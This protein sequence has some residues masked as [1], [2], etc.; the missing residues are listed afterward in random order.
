MIQAEAASLRASGHRIIHLGDFNGHIGS[1][2]GQGVVGNHSSINQNGHRFLNFLQSTDSVHVNGAC[3]TPGQWDTRI[4][5]GLWT[6][7][8]GGSSSVID[9]AVVS[10]EHLNS[11]VSLVVDD[12]GRYGAG[13]SDHNWLFLEILDKF[14][15]KKRITAKS[16]GHFPAWNISD[17]QDWSGYCLNLKRRLLGSSGN[18]CDVGSLNTLICESL[19]GALTDE[20]G[21]KGPSPM[22]TP[23]RLPRNIVDELVYRRQLEMNW[24]S[25]QSALASQ[26]AFLVQPADRCSVRD[27]E[28]LF[29]DQQAKV[30]ELLV[31]HRQVKRTSLLVDCKAPSLRANKIFWSHVSAAKKQSTDISAV[32][33]PVS[34]VLECG[35]EEIKVEVENHLLSTFQGSFKCPTPLR[36]PCLHEDHS[37]SS[38]APSSMPDHHYSIHPRPVMLN[39]DSSQ[40]METNPSAWLNMDFTV[41]EVETCVRRLK[42]CKAKG[43]DRIPNEALKNSPPEL[44]VLIARL[45]N[46]IKSSGKIPHGWNRGRITLI[47]KSDL[48]EN[49]GIYRP[50][51]VIIS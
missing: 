8:R 40:S 6:R 49:L 1:V 47:H 34:G 36:H 12:A 35:F 46:L 23:R 43:W 28:I 30:A 42:N 51:T 50:I 15:K 3:R 18:T 16:R 45:F 13:G 17:D 29:L 32:I 44:L 21:L 25:K 4:S 22:R 24:K 33:S 27:A 26:P 20:I 31:S 9:Y 37:Y 39:L 10:R 5:S 7:Q 41:S 14:V 48:R 38:S 11:V 2:L 19:L